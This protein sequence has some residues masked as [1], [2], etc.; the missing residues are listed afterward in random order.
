MN[1]AER[2]NNAIVSLV[3]LNPGTFAALERDWAHW[4][5]VRRHVIAEGTPLWTRSLTP[6]HMRY[7]AAWARAKKR[8]ARTPHPKTLTT[9]YA[10]HVRE[11]IDRRIEAIVDTGR[12]ASKAIRP[13]GRGVF[14]FGG[15]ALLVFAASRGQRR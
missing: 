10:V 9:D 2:L 7:S 8:S 11:D 15:L 12:A 14:L 13:W 6:F 1:M 3:A 5:S 4:W